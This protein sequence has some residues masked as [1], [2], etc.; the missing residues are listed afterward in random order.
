MDSD[1]H[2][3]EK[4]PPTPRRSNAQGDQA[5]S[6]HSPEEFRKG[7]ESPSD[8]DDRPGSE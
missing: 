6:P 8:R 2:S 5:G 4:R 7:K 1:E 3:E